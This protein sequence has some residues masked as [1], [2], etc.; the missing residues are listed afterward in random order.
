MTNS[1]FEQPLPDVFKHDVAS[2][3]LAEGQVMPGKWHNYPMQAPASLWSTPTDLALFSLS[4]IQAWNGEEGAL[5]SKDLCDQY[6]SEHK[7]QW[8]LGP[9]LFIQDGKTIGFHHGGANEGYRCNSVAFLNGQGAVVM[10]NS[11]QSDALLGEIMAAAATVYDWPEHHPKQQAWLPLSAENQERFTGVFTSTIGSKKYEALVS[12][13]GQGLDI[14][15]PDIP[16]S[17]PFYF[18]S[19]EDDKAV[20]ISPA[21]M[22]IN[23]TEDDKQ[24]SIVTILGYAFTR[25]STPED[26]QK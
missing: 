2:G 25:T 24:Q 3:H 19:Q 26:N 9:R 16:L 23:F 4:V 11:D 7:N 13:Q 1:T 15:C 5:F 20:F 21:G 10:T 14:S 17:G 12:L 18:I 22:K 8:G 6:L